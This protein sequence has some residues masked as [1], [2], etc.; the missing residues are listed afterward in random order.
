V[1]GPAS[2]RFLAETI[3]AAGNAFT[4]ATT[5]MGAPGHPL[6]EGVME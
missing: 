5:L 2:K 1:N 6:A 3:G 4:V